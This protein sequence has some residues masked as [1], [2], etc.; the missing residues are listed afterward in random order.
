MYLCLLFKQ[1]LKQMIQYDK[2]LCE[3]LDDLYETKQ[4]K[5]KKVEQLKD[6]I[7]RDAHK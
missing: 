5:E 2:T 1:R 3:E 4:A 6:E 7:E